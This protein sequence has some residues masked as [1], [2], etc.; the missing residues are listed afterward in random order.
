MCRHDPSL[1]SHFFDRSIM[2]YLAASMASPLCFRALLLLSSLSDIS[3]PR[4]TYSR[5]SIARLGTI[6]TCSLRLAVS[7]LTETGT[8]D[9]DRPDCLQSRFP[10]A[11]QRLLSPAGEQG[12]SFPSEDTRP[13][14][15]SPFGRQSFA[16]DAVLRSCLATAPGRGAPWGDS[17]SP[18]SSFRPNF[19]AS[20]WCS[21]LPTSSR[22]CEGVLSARLSPSR[23]L[24]AGPRAVVAGVVSG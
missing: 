8:A 1:S 10:F 22:L 4:A 20:L 19:D 12:S 14:K 11:D 17:W 24:S 23:A 21:L 18:L 2:H 3:R 13:V 15:A 6:S 9:R 5:A 16:L 7:S